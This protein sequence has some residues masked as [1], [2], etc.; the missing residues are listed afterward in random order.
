MSIFQTPNF[1]CHLLRSI[2]YQVLL[3]VEHMHSNQVVHRDLK[4][5][6]IIIINSGIRQGG[7]RESVGDRGKECVE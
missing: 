4:V 6:K 1:A 5:E 7:G 2:M 3:A